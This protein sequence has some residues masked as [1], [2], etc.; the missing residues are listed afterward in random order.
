MQSIV[1]ASVSSNAMDAQARVIAYLP[2]CD[3]CL[4]SSLSGASSSISCS[5]HSQLFL[6]LFRGFRG[7]TSSLSL[8]STLQSV[9][10]VPWWLGDSCWRIAVRLH[11]RTRGVCTLYTY[12]V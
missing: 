4:F 5:P 3:V 11:C 6:S 10:S 1:G 9:F 7:T 8:S 12:F 2:Q